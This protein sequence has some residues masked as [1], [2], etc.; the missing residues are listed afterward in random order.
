M[1]NVSLLLVLIGVGLNSGAQLLLKAGMERI[2]YFAFTWQNIYPVVGKIV[3]NPYILMGLASY[4]IS[5]G[6]WLLA[7]SRVQVSIAYP[8]LS[9]GYVVNAILAHYWLHEQLSLPRISGIC[10]ILLGVYLV[11][12]S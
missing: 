2:G 9:L 10:V 7:L 3:V 1:S 4:V 5:V 12:R 6:V 11:A 8:L